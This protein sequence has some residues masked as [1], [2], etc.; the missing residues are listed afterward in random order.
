MVFSGKFNEDR[1][2]VVVGWVRSI[3]RKSGY[4]VLLR[5]IVCVSNSGWE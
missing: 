4:I 1:V 5:R 3:L 2:L